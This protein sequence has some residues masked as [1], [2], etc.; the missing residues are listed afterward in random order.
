MSA[1]TDNVSVAIP[2]VPIVPDCPPLPAPVAITRAPRKRLGFLSAL[3]DA[4]CEIVSRAVRGTQAL[5]LASQHDARAD[6]HVTQMNRIAQRGA[7]ESAALYGCP[8]A[9]RFLRV[10]EH[11]NGYFV[12]DGH[13][14]DGVRAGAVEFGGIG[15]IGRGMNRALTR[16]LGK[17]GW[18]GGAKS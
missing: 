3:V 17:R 18:T 12:E 1:V 7:E 13:E 4:G 5:A 2:T 14:D 15:G 8:C 11:G 16:E 6:W 10:V 9:A